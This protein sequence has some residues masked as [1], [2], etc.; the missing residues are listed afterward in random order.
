MTRS[1]IPF[2]TGFA[3]AFHTRSA[4]CTPRRTQNNSGAHPLAATATLHEL[5]FRI[6]P[7]NRAR[8]RQPPPF[9][10]DFLTIAAFNSHKGLLLCGFVHRAV[11]SP[12]GLT[13]TLFAEGFSAARQMKPFAFTGLIPKHLPRFHELPNVAAKF[14]P[15]SVLRS[16]SRRRLVAFNKDR[17]P[18]RW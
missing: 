12:G 11:S 4:R 2:R 7:A 6:P 3:L 13:L 10:D 14:H 16:Q 8:P 5:S 9:G 15:G 17:A 1:C 18:R